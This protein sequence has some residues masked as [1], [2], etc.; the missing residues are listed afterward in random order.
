M[1]PG[2]RYTAVAVVLHWAIA[3][4]IVANLALGWWMH[5]A[6]DDAGTV[7]RAIAAYQLHK[8]LGLAVLAL[9]LLRVGWRLAHRPPPLP[10]AMPAWERIGARSLHWAFYALL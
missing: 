3:A 10:E 8:S 5:H 2:G 1:S 7:A 6:I 9:T 4:A